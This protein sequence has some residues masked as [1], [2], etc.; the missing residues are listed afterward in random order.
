MDGSGG[1][2][3]AKKRAKKRKQQQQ[4]QQQQQPLPPQPHQAQPAEAPPPKKA[5]KAKKATP[6]LDDIDAVDAALLKGKPIS[7]VSQIFAAAASKP[8]AKGKTSRKSAMAG[9]SAGEIAAGRATTKRAAKLDAH[10]PRD[11]DHNGVRMLTV[12]TGELEDYSSAADILADVG[13]PSDQ[14]ASTLLGWL[15]APVSAEEFMERHFEKQPLVVKRH[16][17]AADWYSGL[18]S[19]GAI[20]KSVKVNRLE[21]GQ[22]VSSSRNPEFCVG[23]VLLLP[24]A[25]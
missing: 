3:A 17:H 6:S 4:Q 14:R 11:V 13:L 15:C 10:D 24:A 7:H 22:E 18:L 20:A 25:L 2:R 21:Q 12:G 1:S 16:A 23:L 5:K 19:T 8:T 9:A